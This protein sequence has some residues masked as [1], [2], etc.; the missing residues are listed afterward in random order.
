MVESGKKA[1]AIIAKIGNLAEQGIKEVAIKVMRLSLMLSMDLDAIIAG[2]PH[3][4]AI[5]IGIKQRPDRP[6]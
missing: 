5:T 3:P 4:D 1:A 2:T 6:K